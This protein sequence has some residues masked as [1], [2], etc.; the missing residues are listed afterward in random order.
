VAFHLQFLG[1]L[2]ERRRLE[3]VASD[4]C[5]ERAERD[6]AGVAD[7]SCVEVGL[8]GSLRVRADAPDRL[9]VAQLLGNLHRH[10]DAVYLV[11]RRQAAVH[12][13]PESCRS[14]VFLDRPGDV[15]DITAA[16]AP[17]AAAGTGASPTM[18]RG[19]LNHRLQQGAG[20]RG[21]VSPSDRDPKKPFN[22][23]TLALD[24]SKAW[25]KIGLTPIGLHECRYSYAGY[26]IAAGVNTKALS[27]RTGHS[28]ITIT[29]DRYGHVL[30]AN[31]N[32][33]AELLDATPSRACRDAYASVVVDD[34]LLL[35]HDAAISPPNDDHAV[36]SRHCGNRQ[37]AT[38]LRGGSNR[39]GEDL[40]RM[41]VECSRT[42]LAEHREQFES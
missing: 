34:Q 9:P 4:I 19:L 16:S 13:V 23:S 17:R 33:A 8:D 30:P 42:R 24:T 11:M 28:S 41:H 26:M 12:V 35:E 15:T 29:L 10:G 27:T 31:E 39:A 40:V 6:R 5:S 1:A 2:D 32:E 25:E 21:F 14:F 18:R 37:L 3:V 38:V 20:G 7:A 22:P 36:R